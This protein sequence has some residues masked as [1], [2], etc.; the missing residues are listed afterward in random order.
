MS[1]PAR[2]LVVDDNQTLRVL[3]AQALEAAGYVA[4]GADS[5]ESALEVLGFD[6]PDLCLV[7]QHMPGMCGAD[8][9]RWMRRSSDVRLRAIPAIGLT[10]YES[11]RRDLIDAGACEA[12]A[13]PCSEGML[14][15]RVASALKAAS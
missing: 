2:I 1:R 7:D 13:K 10:G 3:L 11:A 8:L 15:D 4:I 6:P 12:L 5:A 14:L 9:I